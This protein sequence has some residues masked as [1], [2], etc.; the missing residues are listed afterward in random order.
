[1]T[2]EQMLDAL[3]RR[4]AT[5]PW[6]SRVEHLRKDAALSDTPFQL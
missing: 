2:R 3:V 6:K 4:S 1:M 5:E